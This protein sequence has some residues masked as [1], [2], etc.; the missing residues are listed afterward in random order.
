MKITKR[1]KFMLSEA[2][3]FPIHRYLLANTYG[4]EDPIERANRHMEISGIIVGFIRCKKYHEI[5]H[6]SIMKEVHDY[7]A[8]I[9]TDRMDEVIG[10][11]VFERPHNYD[12]LVEKFINVI[13]NYMD[14]I[15]KIVKE[16]EKE[17]KHE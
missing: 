7:L 17:L 2:L 15:D 5:F 16:A 4:R 13:F 11:P 8:E 12:E 9:L 1:E 6:F 14:D 3:D 10:F